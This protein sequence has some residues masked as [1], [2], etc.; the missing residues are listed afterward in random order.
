MFTC[1]FTKPSRLHVWHSTYN[2]HQAHNYINVHVN[3]GF[4]YDSHV[5]YVVATVEEKNQISHQSEALA[6]MKKEVLRRR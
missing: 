4:N 5:M 6:G 1:I 3:I 2:S